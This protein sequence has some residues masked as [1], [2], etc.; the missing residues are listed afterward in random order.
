MRHLLI[1]LLLVGTL[2][3]SCSQHDTDALEQ[4]AAQ[5]VGDIH[6]IAPWATGGIRNGASAAYATFANTG[7]HN[8]TLL[9][10]SSPACG[11]VELHEMVASD[12]I[13]KM[14]HIPFLPVPASGKARLKPGGTHIMLMSLHESLRKGDSLT[15]NLSFA[16][17]GTTQLRVEVR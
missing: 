9:S 13:K 10:V 7:E 4:Q 17:A 15:L 3:P 2:L 14:R 16:R 6:I 1:A 11:T 8:D 12:G 5:S